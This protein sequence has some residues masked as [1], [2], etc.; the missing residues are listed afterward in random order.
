MRRG[1]QPARGPRTA[2]TLQPTIGDVA[3][4]AGVSRAT[5]SRVLNE[6]PHVR[7]QV[8]TDVQRA[9]RA[10]RYRPDQVARSLARRETKTLGLVV[11]D[12]TNPFYA[13]TARAIVETARGHGYNVILCNTD[14]LH[15]L[16]EEYVEVLRQRRVDGIIFGSVFLDDPVVEALVEAGYP[17][18][19]YNRRL[20]SGRGNYIVLDNASASHD[21]TRHLLDLGHRH[22][23]FITGLRDL[24]T[25]SERL[26]GYRAALRAA[27]L[28][29]D[30]RLMRPG[31]FKAEM[32]QRAAQELLK[33][34]RRPTA[35]MAGN[36]L[37]AL[38]V[39]Q[40]AGDLG[41]RVPEDLAVV[42]F[43]DIE[44]AAHRQIQL[45]TMAQQKAEMGRMAVVWML[46][47]IRDPRRYRREPLQQILTPTLV[48]RRTCGALLRGD[49]S[50][51]RRATV[52]RPGRRA[53]RSGE[54][55][56]LRVPSSRKEKR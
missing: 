37:M 21:L 7:P 25:A 15:R 28:P 49:K 30:S 50:G 22:I 53:G 40:A 20:R 41:L 42:G 5:V 51:D 56:A 34:P 10:L 24:S 44:I 45:T 29:A 23:G 33:L 52:P 9:I 43:D 11:A 26:R 31:A 46:E 13:E 14:N 48:V 6:Y 36:D 16:Q 27:G 55:K 54:G 2:K 4:R 1:R 47:I 38:G 17:C 12:I 32:A 18:V 19:M 8:R 35:I 39:M 3:R